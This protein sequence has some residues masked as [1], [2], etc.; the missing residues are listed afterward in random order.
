MQDSWLAENGLNSQPVLRIAFLQG[1]ID[2]S[3]GF[4]SFAILLQSAALH[5]QRVS[6]WHGVTWC[7][8]SCFFMFCASRAPFAIHF[9]VLPEICQLPLSFPD[10]SNLN[11]KHFPK[12]QGATWTR[13]A[14]A[15]AAWHCQHKQHIISSVKLPKQ[16]FEASVWKTLHPDTVLLGSKISH[17]QQE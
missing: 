6:Q 4:W 16:M 3:S 11:D 5:F 7:Y 14:P 9:S 2:S 10:I 17:E 15:R 12:H 1:C 13:R 8:M